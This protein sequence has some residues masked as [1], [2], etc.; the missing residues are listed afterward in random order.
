MNVVRRSTERHLKRSGTRRFVPRP[1]KY[2]VP[3]LMPIRTEFNLDHIRPQKD[4]GDGRAMFV[5]NFCEILLWSNV[6]FL[7]TVVPFFLE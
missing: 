7:K 3:P 6:V 2:T 4:D 5:E 1:T